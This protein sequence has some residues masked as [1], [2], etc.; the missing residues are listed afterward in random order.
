MSARDLPLGGEGVCPDL[1][2]AG[3]GERERCDDS[4][5]GLM[6]VGLPRG[7]ITIGGV[8]SGR[9]TGTRL[10]EELAGFRP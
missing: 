2:M 3:S 10:V 7:C 4:P 6:G 1:I 5:I 9:V 8:S